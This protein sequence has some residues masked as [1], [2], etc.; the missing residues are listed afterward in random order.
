MFL[1]EEEILLK[2]VLLRPCG[3]LQKFPITAIE[4]M[5][6]GSFCFAIVF[7]NPTIYDRNSG[8]REI[9]SFGGKKIKKEI[10]IVSQK[11]SKYQVRKRD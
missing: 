9:G 5:D 3:K 4:Y 6:G 11:E 10:K 1:E 8:N 7:L 2:L